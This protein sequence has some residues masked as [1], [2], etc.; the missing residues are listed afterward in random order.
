MRRKHSR[1]G[2]RPFAFPFL[3]R[4]PARDVM[5]SRPTFRAAAGVPCAKDS[6]GWPGRARTGAGAPVVPVEELLAPGR[7]VVPDVARLNSTP[8]R[9]AVARS[10]RMS[11]LAPCRI[12]LV[13]ARPAM[14]MTF[15]P[16]A[17][18]S[19][20]RDP[21]ENIDSDSDPPGR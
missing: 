9:A 16:T 5:V 19:G 10:R 15:R 8:P 2:F 14:V 12:T 11:L 13:I 1:H 6:R 21:A 4:C 3:R 7:D 18:H 17:A 20:S